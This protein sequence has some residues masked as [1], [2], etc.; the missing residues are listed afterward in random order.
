MDQIDIPEPAERLLGGFD[1]EFALTEAPD[2]E[3]AASAAKDAFIAAVQAT[4]TGLKQRKSAVN[5]QGTSHIETCNAELGNPDHS[6][7]IKD[8]LAS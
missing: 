7:L 5:Q 8:A 1:S 4:L 6:L 3:Q 2:L